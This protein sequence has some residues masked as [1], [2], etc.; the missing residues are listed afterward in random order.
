[1]DILVVG[2]ETDQTLKD[3]KGINRPINTQKDRCN[4]LSEVS[5]IDF[6]FPIEHTILYGVNLDEMHL[7]YL[8]IYKKT[9]AT[10]IIT[11]TVTDKYW[12]GKKERAKRLGIQLLK[13][14]KARPVS[15]S[16]ILE[17]GRSS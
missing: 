15:T 17:K 4:F 16:A 2:L 8:N 13:Q 11:N 6:V 7:K 9:F 3:S 10:H 5:S 12:H 14:I 1:M